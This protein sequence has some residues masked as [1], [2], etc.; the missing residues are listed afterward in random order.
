MKDSYELCI[1]VTISSSLKLHTHKKPRKIKDR[2]EVFVNDSLALQLLTT[3]PNQS[4]RLRV[5]L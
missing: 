4:S 1:N 2:E 3:A 5:T